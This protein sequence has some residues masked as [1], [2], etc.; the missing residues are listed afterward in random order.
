MGSRRA[1]RPRADRPAGEPGDASPQPAGAPERPRPAA[2]PLAAFTVD[3]TAKARA[4]ELD[5]LVG[6]QREIARALE[7]L[8]RRRKNNPVFVGEAGSARP[9]SWR[10]SRSGSPPRMRPRRCGGAEVFALDGGA[11]LAGDALPRRLRGALQGPPCGSRAARESRSSSST[12][13]TRSVGAG[14]DQ[15]RHMD[16]ANL[17][18]AGAHAGE[19]AAA[20]STTFEEFKQIEKDRALHRRL[21]KIAVE[22][23]SSASACASSRG[24][25]RATRST[26]A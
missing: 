5:P 18:Q 2:D 19:G 16:L 23:P 8:C 26:T 22:E 20:G 7:V 10:G 6:R 12:S 21:Q 17:P 9:R 25:A 11:L 3:L 14:R 13:C 24:C 15:R 1:R 4:G